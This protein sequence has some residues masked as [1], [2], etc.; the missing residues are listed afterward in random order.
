MGETEDGG[1]AL[2]G[3]VD[4]FLSGIDVLDVPNEIMEIFLFSF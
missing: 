1:S 2:G 3:A 4:L